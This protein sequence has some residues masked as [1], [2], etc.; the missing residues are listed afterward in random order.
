[1]TSL[2]IRAT[3]PLLLLTLGCAQTPRL[4]AEFGNAVKAARL[5]QTIAP[6]PPAGT[7]VN[8]VDG[9]AAKSAYDAY[10]K[11]FKTPQPQTGALT[12]G[13]GR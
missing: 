5:A 1:M 2:C 10:Q 3:V 4:D 12:V 9:Q 8:G 11:S 6:Q 13:V 7:A